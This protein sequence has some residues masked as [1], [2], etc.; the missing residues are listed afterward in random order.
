MT[1][2]RLGTSWWSAWACSCSARGSGSTLQYAVVAGHE[3]AVDLLQT[4]L[5][6]K[7]SHLDPVWFSTARTAR[8]LKSTLFNLISRPT[9]RAMPP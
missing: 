7:L 6:E 5:R 2:R 3:A 9:W 4:V 1:R 8:P